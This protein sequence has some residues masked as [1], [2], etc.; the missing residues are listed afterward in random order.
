MLQIRTAQPRRGIAAVFTLLVGLLKFGKAGGT[1]ITMLVSLAVY[2]GIFGWK[3]AAGFIA[4]VLHEMG[5]Y[6]AVA[7][8]RWAND[9]HPVAGLA[10]RSCWR[11]PFFIPA[12]CSCSS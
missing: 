4:L 9:R 11:G 6:S 12:P 8:G 7:A 5:H 1:V 3:Y 10:R 2:T